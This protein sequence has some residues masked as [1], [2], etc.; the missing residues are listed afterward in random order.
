MFGCV[1]SSL[2]PTGVLSR[3]TL[4]ILGNM[5]I[6]EEVMCKLVYMFLKIYFRCSCFLYVA[7]DFDEIILLFY[8]FIYYMIYIAPISRI[9]SHTAVSIAVF[10]F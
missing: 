8:L 9:E 10:T 2:T 7:T 4:F 5:R 1:F 6:V 3:V